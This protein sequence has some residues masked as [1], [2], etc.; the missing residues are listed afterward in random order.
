MSEKLS[1]PQKK[2]LETVAL[3]VVDLVAAAG[4]QAN[5]AEIV[6]RVVY[7]SFKKSREMP[8]AIQ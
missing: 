4:L 7:E 6:L 2:R 5:E 3:E 1:S 8:R